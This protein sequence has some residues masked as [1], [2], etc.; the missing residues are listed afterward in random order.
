MPAAVIRAYRNGYLCA[1]LNGDTSISDVPI[2]LTWDNR[3]RGLR[4]CRRSKEVGSLLSASE[5]SWQLANRFRP[6]D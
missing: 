6:D 3:T 2:V 1:E 5:A 4:V